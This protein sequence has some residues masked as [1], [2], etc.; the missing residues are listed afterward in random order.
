[1]HLRR[2]WRYFFVLFSHTT[3]Q[4][5]KSTGEWLYS[6]TDMAVS[7]RQLHCNI[8]VQGH[9]PLIERE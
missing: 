5:H 6:V 8:A 7:L 4:N 9:E 2:R 3:F 1:V